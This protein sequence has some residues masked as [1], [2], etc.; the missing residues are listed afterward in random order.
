MICVCPVLWNFTQRGMVS[1]YRRFVKPIGSDFQRSNFSLTAW[2]LKL[3]PIGYLETSIRNYHSMLCKIPEC[4]R[5]RLKSAAVRQIDVCG[6]GCYQSELTGSVS[7]LWVWADWECELTV[8]VSWLRV[9]WQ[10]EWAD[11]ECELT[12]RVSWQWERAVRVSWH[13]KW[14]DCEN[15]LTVGVS[16]LWECAPVFAGNTCQHLPRLRETA[17]NTERCI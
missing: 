8:S 14:A 6:E 11:C 3:V 16:W 12:V 5:S 2:S 4:S 10:W 15:E 1:P 9:S 7:W 17:D 13:W